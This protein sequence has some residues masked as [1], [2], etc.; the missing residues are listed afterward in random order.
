[1]EGS[2]L[3]GAG[4]AGNTLTLLRRAGRGKKDY[5]YI[6]ENKLFKWL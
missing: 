2:G 1:M 6:I 5:D 4:A 3:S